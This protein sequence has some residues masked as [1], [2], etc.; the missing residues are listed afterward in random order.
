MDKTRT[1]EEGLRV[2]KGVFPLCLLFW[3]AITLRIVIVDISPSYLIP[4]ILIIPVIVTHIKDRK[5][6]E[7]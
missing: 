7:G 6:D 2:F 3:T 4:W 1:K 5:G